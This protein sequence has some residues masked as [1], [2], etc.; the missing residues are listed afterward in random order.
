MLVSRH[1]CRV[2]LSSIATPIARGIIG[3]PTH[4]KELRDEALFK[5]PK[6][7]ICFLPMPYKLTSCISLLPATR[8]SV[9]I[10][11]FAEAK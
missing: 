3:R 10:H 6:C 4:K 7:P 9:P 11:D 8:S 5:D 2:F 1:V